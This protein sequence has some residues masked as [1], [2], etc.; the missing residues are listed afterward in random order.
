MLGS[1]AL[2]L[3]SGFVGEFMLLFGVYE[4]NTW[5]GAF[6]GLTIILGSCLYV[7]DVSESSFGQTYY[8]KHGFSR[9]NVERR[10]YW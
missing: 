4:Y 8:G 2:P 10:W 5:L 6:A 3:S 1:I 7:K 9:F